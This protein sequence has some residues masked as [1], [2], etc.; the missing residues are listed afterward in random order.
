MHDQTWIIALLMILWIVL[1]VC[2]LILGLF[3]NLLGL[4][5]NWVILGTMIVHGLLTESTS[6]IG[7]TWPV[8]F[9]LAV[10][11]V[12]GEGLEALAGLMGAGKAG[13]SR[14]AL[15]LSFFGAMIGAGFGFGIGNAVMPVLGGIAGVFLL[16]ALGALAGA[17]LGETWKGR[18]LQESM[19]VGK[20]AF[21]GRLLGTVSKTFVGT[22]MLLVALSALVF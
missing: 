15:L 18:S 12:T 17:V 16:G 22:T 2:L 9:L 14:R 3:L 6:R 4:A 8:I 1:L 5:G 20:G 21:V 10:L 19:E 13:A 11:A 7:V